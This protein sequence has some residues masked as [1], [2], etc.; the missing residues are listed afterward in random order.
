MFSYKKIRPFMI[1]ILF[2][3]YI[4]TSLMVFPNTM[5][6]MNLGA[7]NNNGEN[8]WMDLDIDPS[9]IDSMNKIYSFDDKLD[10]YLKKAEN[11]IDKNT[12]PDPMDED[13]I[14]PEKDVSKEYFIS[15]HKTGSKKNTQI[16][17]YKKQKMIH[18]M[19]HI[20]KLENEILK[21]FPDSSNDNKQFKYINPNGKD[22]RE[23]IVKTEETTWVDTPF[24]YC[25]GFKQKNNYLIDIKKIFISPKNI[26]RGSELSVKYDA[27][28]KKGSFKKGSNVLITAIMNGK[29]M[30]QR[31]LSICDVTNCPINPG[32]FNGVIKH[33]LPTRMFKGQYLLEIN[34]FNEV[35][36]K[37]P[38]TCINFN[39][40]AN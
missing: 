35:D 6:K 8:N 23:P 16:P 20:K 31:S 32:S 36:K 2:I 5:K 19:N 40:N 28:I 15:Q 27:F 29:K 14:V 11:S 1:T 25:A 13:S 17:N 24:Q 21:H 30:L 26:H 22:N 39:I 9:E 7:K 38:A 10:N 3:V 33:K 18:S 37:N 34:I 4:S 12:D